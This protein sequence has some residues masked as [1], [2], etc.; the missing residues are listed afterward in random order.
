MTRVK[1]CGF[2]REE[3]VRL[4]V[5]LGVDYL[6]LNFV[7]GT[8][9]CISPA[10]ARGLVEAAHDEAR[11]SGSP[12][13]RLVGVFGP[14]DR[15]T[16]EGIV[17]QCG[18]DLVQMHLGRAFTNAPSMARLPVPAI[19]ALRC[20]PGEEPPGLEQV[21]GVYAHLLDGYHPTSLGGTGLRADW[22]LASRLARTGRLIL[23][24]GLS[25]ANVAQAIGEVHPYAVDVASGVEQAPGIKDEEQMALFVHAV[26]SADRES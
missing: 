10:R 26:R 17:Q 15:K 11:R 20:R 1:F 18:L 12:P 16:V 5:R 19:L 4:A 3:D 2:R 14:M 7:P 25:A 21:E 13:V 23:A 8:P 6:G 9:R 24:G 22:A